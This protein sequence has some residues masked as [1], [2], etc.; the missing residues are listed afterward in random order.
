MLWDA[1]SINGYA[2]LAS[3]GAIGQVSDIL[4]EDE[5]WFVP[6]LIVDT[7][8][9]LAGHR[10]ML[11]FSALGSLNAVRRQIA[12]RLTMQEIKDSEAYVPANTAGGAWNE[13]FQTYYGIRWARK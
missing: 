7:G 3:D 8:Q 9:F 1:S 5:G 6:W 2:I 11:P 4:I 12:V 10:V 13:G